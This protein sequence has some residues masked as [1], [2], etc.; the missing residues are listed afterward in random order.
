MPYVQ[1]P[2]GTAIDGLSQDYTTAGR[3]NSATLDNDQQSATA[4]NT[5]THSGQ[6]LAL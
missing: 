6:V 1:V 3:I 2:E 5:H 4:D